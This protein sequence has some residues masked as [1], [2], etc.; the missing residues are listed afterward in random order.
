MSKTKIQEDLEYLAHEG[1]KIVGSEFVHH[2]VAA[3]MDAKEKIVLIAP[4]TNDSRHY[5]QFSFRPGRNSHELEDI[6][7]EPTRIG[8]INIR[9]S[10]GKHHENYRIYRNYHDVDHANVAI[11]KSGEKYEISK[12]FKD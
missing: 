6:V 3:R 8:V 7:I 10:A 11:L 12:I 5:I 2:I 4:A 9:L 1:I